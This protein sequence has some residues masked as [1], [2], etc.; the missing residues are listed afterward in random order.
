[1]DRL[2]SRLGLD[3]VELRR[4][5]LVGPA[6]MPYDTGLNSIVYDGGDYPRLLELA[7]G[8]IGAPS[9][10]R[11]QLAGEPVGVGVAMCVESTGIG[12]PEPSRVAVLA[13]GAGAA[14][15]SLGVQL[16]FPDV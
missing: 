11:R 4:R 15:A 6:D 9:I 1:M 2:A 16:L 8:R 3:P 12:M 5:N 10:R 14:D 13:D 7:V